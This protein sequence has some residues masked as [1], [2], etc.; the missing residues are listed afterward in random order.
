MHAVAAQVCRNAV[1]GSS[2]GNRRI[3][4]TLRSRTRVTGQGNHVGCLPQGGVLLQLG[5]VHEAVAALKAGMVGG[6]V[7]A[8]QVMRREVLAPDGVLACHALSQVG[9]SPAQSDTE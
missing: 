7:A 8:W 3:V 5:R 2:S 9:A 4:I 6:S 1:S